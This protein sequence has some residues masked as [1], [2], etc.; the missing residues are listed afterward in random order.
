MTLLET[1]TQAPAAPPIL[2]ELRTIDS[3]VAWT[4]REVGFATLEP[5]ASELVGIVRRVFTQL[6]DHDDAYVVGVGSQ[7]CESSYLLGSSCNELNGGGSPDGRQARAAAIGEAIERY[8]VA[9]AEPEYFIRATS[10][11]LTAA[12]VRHTGPERLS[13]FA[14]DQFDNP[15]FPF[16]RF[17]PELSLDWVWTR[18]LLDDEPT[19]VPARLVY[20]QSALPTEPPIGYATSNGLACA[21]TYEEAVVS[22]LGELL[23]RDA[24]MATWYGKLSLPRID[25]A[26]SPQLQSF[27]DQHVTPTGLD[28]ALINLSE[29]VDFPVVLAVVRNEHTNIAPLALG[30]AGASDP[31]VAC[32]KAVIEAFQTRTWAKAEQR[33]G[34][35]LDPA[36]GFEQVETFDDHVRMSIHPTVAEVTRFLDASETVLPLDALPSVAADTPAAA[37]H[38]IV[39]RLNRQGVRVSAVDVTSPDVAAGG[40]CV[41]KVFSPELSPL[42]SGYQNRYL[43]GA[44]LRKRA[45]Q[46]GLRDRELRFDELNPFPHP[47]P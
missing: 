19:L 13:L 30:A 16:A 3:Q 11:D 21:V 46:V 24:F 40:L 39:G 33:E 1:D 2:K 45:A 47:F 7:A 27:F 23:E 9:W 25:V 42:D 34:A 15:R 36:D 32:Y 6:H 10:A 29:L 5:F 38:E 35:V 4:P 14:A 17:D 37:I 31:F 43:G 12:G 8:S 18:D 22:G 20:M 28:V 44:R 26:S 41:A